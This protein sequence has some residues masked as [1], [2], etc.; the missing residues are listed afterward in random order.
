MSNIPNHINPIL[1]ILTPM[2]LAILII[3]NI[4]N[5]ITVT[6]INPILIP[7]DPNTFLGSGTGVWFGGDLYLLRQWPWI[8]RESY[9]THLFSW[10][11]E[12]S[13]PTSPR[14]AAPG[15]GWGRHGKIYV[16]DSV[17]TVPMNIQKRVW[18]IKNQHSSN[19]GESFIHLIH[20]SIYPFQKSNSIG[21][22]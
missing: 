16:D 5:H 17:N 18:F 4:P 15:W 21:M 7:M 22:V 11:L 9:V 12:V 14:A 10:P 2:K 3:S 8:H 19:L 20:L 6:N 1:T 13:I